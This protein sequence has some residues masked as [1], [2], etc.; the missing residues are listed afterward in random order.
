MKKKAYEAYD[1]FDSLMP[2][3]PGVGGTEYFFSRPVVSAGQEGIVGH[4]GALGGIPTKPIPGQST[5]VDSF[6]KTPNK[7]RRNKGITKKANEKVLDSPQHSGDNLRLTP[8]EERDMSLEKEASGMISAAFFDELQKI[9]HGNGLE[10]DAQ[11]GAAIKGI[12]KGIMGAGKAGVSSAKKSLI[13]TAKGKRGMISRYA[14]AAKTGIGSAAKKLTPG[15]AA[16]VAGVA[17]VGAGAT[18]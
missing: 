12:A 16:T 11:I 7:A 2:S 4:A 3:G 17:G 1:S 13:G 9:S 15:Q 14:K 10:K 6:R 8:M 18:L 5:R